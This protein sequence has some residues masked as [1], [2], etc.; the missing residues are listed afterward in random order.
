[1]KFDKKFTLLILAAIILIIIYLVFDKKSKDET[2]N[3]I[4]VVGV[5]PDYPPFEFIREG[6]VVGFDMDFAK[7]LAKRMK[8]KVEVREMDFSALIPSL[9]SKK[10][11]V[12]I[13]ALSETPERAKKISFSAPYYAS[14]FSLIIRIG[15]DFESLEEFL[16]NA[17]VGVQTGSTMEKFINYY[18][19]VKDNDINVVSISSNFVLLEKLKIGEISAMVV[20]KPQAPEFVNNN[21]NL[22]YIVLPSEFPGNKGESYSIGV[23]KN[24]DLLNEINR[25]I[26]LLN[27]SH[28]MDKLLKK[29]NLN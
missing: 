14:S 27:T 28:K 25:V 24:S 19:S 23:R 22:K 10:I 20:E 7:A 5:S 2:S 26:D 11:D 12:V 17:K 6:K 1:M 15:S 3:E 21:P 4:L 8:K 13:S 16:K 29:W 9:N 18:K